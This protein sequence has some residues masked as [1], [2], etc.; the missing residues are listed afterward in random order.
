VR[1]TAI[2][3]VAQCGAIGDTSSPG[4]MPWPRL[5]R[6]MR[7]FRE[8][9]DGKVVLMGRKTY[10]TLP[11]KGLPGR[12]LAVVTRD[13]ERCF[14]AAPDPLA[15]FAG[16]MSMEAMLAALACL[17]DE[18]VFVIGGAD[19]FRQLLPRCDRMLL[20]EVCASYPLADVRLD[21]PG[22]LTEGW[23]RLSSEHHATEEGTPLPLRFSE[24]VRP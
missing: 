5:G 7:H 3:A 12:R 20:T 19:I 17:G 11:P 4:G 2:L 6:D 1:L 21:P 24:W 23:H 10:E 9:T 18:E 14:P 22:V 13:R 15:V 8:R 16:S